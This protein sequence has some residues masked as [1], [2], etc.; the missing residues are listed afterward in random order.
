MMMGLPAWLALMLVIALPVLLAGIF[1]VVR[2]VGARIVDSD[3][4]ARP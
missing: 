1:V 2:V 4:P 3:H